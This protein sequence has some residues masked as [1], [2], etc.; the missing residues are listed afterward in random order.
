MNI[1]FFSLFLLTTNAWGGFFENHARGWHWYEKKTK[2]EEVHKQ[3][4]TVILATSTTILESIQKDLKQRLH[5]ALLFPTYENVKA[6]QEAQQF[7][8]TQSQKFSQKW[9]EVVF[10]T[11]SLDES[12]HFP[13]MQLARHTYHD[14]KKKS[15]EKSFRN[16]SQRYGL[17]FFFKQSCPYC[18][19][20]APVVKAFA[21]QFGFYV[22]AIS[23][24]G[25]R[26]DSFPGAVTDNGIAKS[27][28]ITVVP[29]IY[30]V[31]PKSKKVLP[32]AHGMSS[33]EEMKE[34]LLFL[35]QQGEGR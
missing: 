24:D 2:K 21:E 17:F 30:A 26:I 34:R 35:S 8:M 19:A 5:K 23:L 31:D 20:F 29:S 6:Y 7:L 11:P 27:L 14:Q 25:G 9:Q 4:K 13:H 22:K 18:H 15:D 16:L 1:I 12:I 28:N 33:I 3:K 10:T 32:I